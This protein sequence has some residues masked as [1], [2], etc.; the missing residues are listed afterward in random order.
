MDWVKHFSGLRCSGVVAE[1]FPKGGALTLNIT[2]GLGMIA[3]GV[4][5]AGILGFIQD[6]SIEKGIKTYDIANNTSLSKNYVTEEKTS[7][8]GDYRAIDQQKLAAASTDEI[9]TIVN[10]QQKAKKEALQRYSHISGC[11]VCQ[12]YGTHHLF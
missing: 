8:F 11:Y 9:A 2:G 5:G 10:V 1:R 3:A 4:I 12:L 7:L 6:S